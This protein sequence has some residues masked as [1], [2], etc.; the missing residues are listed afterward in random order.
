MHL[1][2][3]LTDYPFAADLSLA[4]RLRLLADE[5]PADSLEYRTLQLAADAIVEG[6]SRWCSGR[7]GGKAAI[8][9]DG[10]DSGGAADCS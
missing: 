9:G 8:N 10:P 4:D 6:A 2:S 3:M 7:S 1:D 5:F